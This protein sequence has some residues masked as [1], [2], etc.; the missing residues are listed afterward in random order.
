[1]AVDCMKSKTRAAVKQNQELVTMTKFLI[2]CV[3]NRLCPEQLGLDASIDLLRILKKQKMDDA[4]TEIPK[5]PKNAIR[6]KFPREIRAYGTNAPE[7]KTDANGREIG[8]E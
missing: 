2:L 3:C 8:E 7:W 1:M 4:I 6:L 5:L